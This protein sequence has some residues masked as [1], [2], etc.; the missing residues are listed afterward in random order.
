MI[1]QRR[2]QDRPE[3]QS[4]TELRHTQSL[5]R[6]QIVGERAKNR[7]ERL[8]SYAADVR[9]GEVSRRCHCRI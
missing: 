1:D 3:Y 8:L 9:A 2:G 4:R 7:A 5:P 6:F